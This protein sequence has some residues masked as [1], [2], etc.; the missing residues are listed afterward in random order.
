MKWFGLCQV[1]WAVSSL[2]MQEPENGIPSVFL[3]KGQRT[4]RAWEVEL[5]LKKVTAQD[6]AGEERETKSTSRR[7]TQSGI[8]FSSQ[9][10]REQ[11][12]PIVWL[13]ILSLL[14]S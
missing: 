1:L 5:C 2:Q 14:V 4:R 8:F 6:M 12:N 13:E 9:T 3:R 10:I 7:W 11:E